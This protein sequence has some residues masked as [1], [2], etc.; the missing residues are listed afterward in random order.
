MPALID[1]GA[2]RTVLSPSA[3]AAAGLPTTNYE[4]MV[5]AGGTD[6]VPVHVASIQFP[7]YKFA[8]IEIIEVLS[9]ELPGNLYQCL[10]GR[11]VLTRWKFTYNGRVGEWEIDEEDSAAWVEPP[12]DLLT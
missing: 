4:K 2:G 6:L 10:I 3:V 12:E 9:C 5:R 7:R 8:T 1:T 11:D